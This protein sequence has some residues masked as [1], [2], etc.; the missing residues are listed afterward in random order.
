MGNLG[1]FGVA[2]VMASKMTSVK[3]LCEFKLRIPT[4][5][6]TPPWGQMFRDFKKTGKPSVFVVDDS[7]R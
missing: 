1:N 5:E 4:R 3:T 7:K 6:K 2:L